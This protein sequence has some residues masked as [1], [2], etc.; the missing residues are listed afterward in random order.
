MKKA[1]LLAC[2]AI[3]G[4]GCSVSTRYRPEAYY[5]GNREA[6]DGKPLFKGDAA[7][8]SDGDIDRI[9]NYKLAL[10][11]QCRLALL[12][13]SE[14]NSWRFYSGD[15][16]QLNEAIE[17]GFVGTLRAAPR[18]YD[19]SFLPSLLVPEVRTVGHLREAAARYQADLL[20][21]Y[22][23]RC[24]SYDK[25]KFF[26]PDEVRAYCSVE[27]VLLD[28]RTGIVPFT[29]VE[30]VDVESRKAAEDKD[31]NETIKKNE[32]AATARALGAVATELVK[33]L[34]KAGVKP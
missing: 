16:V 29:S 11:K 6:D 19:A 7:V 20:L 17:K 10:P 32:L 22:R 2:F 18:L 30:T 31:F 25:F 14:A 21:A 15:F 1:T 23:T 33:F 34:D 24:S 3:A 27:A 26:K 5:G 28:V 13:L 4:L 8:L 9:L 12:N